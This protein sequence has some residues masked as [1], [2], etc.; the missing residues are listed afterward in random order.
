MSFQSHDH[1][2]LS[3]EGEKIQG[4][5][6]LEVIDDLKSTMGNN[7]GSMYVHQCLSEM[8]RYYQ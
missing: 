2:E 4:I 3:T 8:L 1:N 6:W 5:K 7:T